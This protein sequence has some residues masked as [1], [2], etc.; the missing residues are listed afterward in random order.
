MAFT[1]L[2]DDCLVAGSCRLKTPK[3]ELQVTN[4]A[5][6]QVIISGVSI[7]PF[8]ICLSGLIP[9]TLSF[10]AKNITKWISKLFKTCQKCIF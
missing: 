8:S 3:D 7:I 1:I 5:H 9:E 4:D 6:I 10:I 2:G